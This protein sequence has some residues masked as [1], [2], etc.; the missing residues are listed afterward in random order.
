MRSHAVFSSISPPSTDCSASRECGGSFEHV[1]LRILKD[2]RDRLGHV[3]AICVE[4]TRNPK[5]T[6]RNSHSAVA[7]VKERG[8]TCASSFSV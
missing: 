7:F 1:D 2:L 6:T 4:W 5:V 8:L 3:D